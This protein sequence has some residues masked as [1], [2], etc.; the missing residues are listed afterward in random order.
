MN[1]KELEE[2][3]AIIQE[4]TGLDAASL[5]FAVNVHAEINRRLMVLDRLR[6]ILLAIPAVTADVKD[7]GPHYKVMTKAIEGI[8]GHESKS[9]C[10]LIVEKYAKLFSNYSKI[11]NYKKDVIK[12]ASDFIAC[13]MGERESKMD[14]AGAIN[15]IKGVKA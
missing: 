7:I 6:M 12:F 13:W 11:G 9:A 10:V 15:K 8:L 2:A 5:E 3:K 4:T 1:K 14:I